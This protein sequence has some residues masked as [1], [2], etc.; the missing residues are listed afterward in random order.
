MPNKPSGYTL[1]CQKGIWYDESNQTV[2]IDGSG[3]YPGD[4]QQ[5]CVGLTNK[6]KREANVTGH[7]TNEGVGYLKL[8]VGNESLE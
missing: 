6:E 2:S 7:P 8:K 3:K 1:T 4:C 5:G